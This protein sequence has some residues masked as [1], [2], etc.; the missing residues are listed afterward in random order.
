[1]AIDI[2]PDALV[3]MRFPGLKVEVWDEDMVRVAQDWALEHGH[4]RAEMWRDSPS[5]HHEPSPNVLREAMLLGIDPFD[6]GLLEREAIDKLNLNFEHAWLLVEAIQTFDW[7]S[8]QTA[9][10]RILRTIPDSR[11]VRRAANGWAEY[12]DRGVRHL[13][14]VVRWPRAPTIPSPAPIVLG[15]LLGGGPGAW[16]FIS[17]AE[18]YAAIEAQEEE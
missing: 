5:W 10:N 9:W 8:H 3:L 12:V 17:V 16:S 11:G 4:E 15:H 2:K 18:M 6:I 14:T 7:V 13:R 1:M